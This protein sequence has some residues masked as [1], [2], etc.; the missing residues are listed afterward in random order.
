MFIAVKQHLAIKFQ[1]LIPKEIQTPYL[2]TYVCTYL[3]IASLIR[4]TE[5]VIGRLEHDSCSV[6]DTPSFYNGVKNNNF[7]RGIK[8]LFLSEVFG[9]RSSSFACCP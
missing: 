3:G 5:P 6:A 1:D 8:I 4:E 7:S 9:K 2:C